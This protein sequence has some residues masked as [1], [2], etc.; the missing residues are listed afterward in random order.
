MQGGIPCRE[1]SPPCRDN[2]PPHEPRWV[3][4]GNWR[5]T[6]SQ[7]ETQIRVLHGKGLLGQPPGNFKEISWARV[8]RLQKPGFDIT[9]AVSGNVPEF[10]GHFLE[11]PGEFMKTENVSVLLMA[12]EKM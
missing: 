5:A 1:D 8:W 2:S 9:Q 4:G 11:F 12:S 3:Q 7:G 10:P 6:L